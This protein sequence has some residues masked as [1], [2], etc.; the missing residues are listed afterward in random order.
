MFTKLNTNL[1]RFYNSIS[2][3]VCYLKFN[4]E[5]MTILIFLQWCDFRS[6]IAT[7]EMLRN[8]FTFI[9]LTKLYDAN[10]LD[11]TTSVSHHFLTDTYY[12]FSCLVVHCCS[13]QTS[14]KLFV[15]F[16]A[17]HVLRRAH[18]QAGVWA[19]TRIVK[20][21]ANLRC[22]HIEW[23]LFPALHNICRNAHQ[24]SFRGSKLNKVS[25]QDQ[26]PRVFFQLKDVLLN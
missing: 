4:L 2:E 11:Q 22:W 16:F 14:K 13:V 15:A 19:P 18:Y 8:T 1:N 21:V 9:S 20:G 10:Y 17:W 26:R 6:E 3:F 23:C 25:W 7:T 5:F 12:I 24:D